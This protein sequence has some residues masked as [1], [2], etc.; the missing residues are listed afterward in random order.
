MSYESS[1]LAKERREGEG[2]VGITRNKKTGNLN[3]ARPFI[4][5]PFSRKRGDY[6]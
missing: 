5:P 4:V 6:A 1:L 2:E 3:D